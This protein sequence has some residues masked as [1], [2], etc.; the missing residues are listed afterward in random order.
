MCCVEAGTRRGRAVAVV[1]RWLGLLIGSASLLAPLEA[2]ADFAPIV[3]DV[4]VQSASGEGRLQV[5]FEAG[6]YEQETG[7][8]Q[9]NLGEPLILRD[10]TTGMPLVTFQGLEVWYRE[11]P[12]V[13]LSFAI[14][15]G[16]AD[17]TI[18]IATGLL[19]FPDINGAVGRATAVM[20]LT[21]LDGNGALLQG[22]GPVGGAYLAQYN[23]GVPGGTTFAELIGLLVA[24]P[25]GSI[26]AQVSIPAAGLFDI[27]DVVSDMSAQFSFRLSPNDMV[28]VQSHYQIIPVPAVVWL[29]AAGLAAGGPRRRRIRRRLSAVSCRPEARR[30]PS[31]ADSQ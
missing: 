17:T 14:L 10:E 13:A 6:H 20:A 22:L 30:S 12:E 24:P 26:L 21:D 23:G 5:L 1:P 31:L 3:V 4:H 7:I 25:G 18:T 8:Y 9:W 27:P 11:D 16:P 19:S 15:N 2:R 28:T 29:L